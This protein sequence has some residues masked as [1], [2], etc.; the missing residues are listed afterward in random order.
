[1]DSI[2]TALEE[3]QKKSTNWHRR[4]ADFIFASLKTACVRRI[5]FDNG[6][7]EYLLI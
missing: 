5:R 7:K 4:K 3:T 1:M 2:M 6:Y